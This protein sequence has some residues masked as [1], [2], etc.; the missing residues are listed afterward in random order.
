MGVSKI[1]MIFAFS[2]TCIS[3]SGM[4]EEA[5]E[6][7]D[8]ITVTATKTERNAFST[9][10]AVA[11]IDQEE[12]EQFIPSSFKDVLEGTPGLSIQGGARRIAEEP[13]IRG[14]SD[15]QLVLRLDGARQNFDQ[16]HRGRFFVDPAL[17]K[18]VEVIRGSASSLYGSGA[19]GGVLSLETKGAKDLLREGQDIGARASAGFQ[20]N[21][22]EF[23]VSGGVYGQA[24]KIDIL[25]NVVYREVF[26]DLI[27]GAG[28]PIVDSQDRIFNGHTKVGFEPTENQRF[29]I[30]ADFFDGNGLNPTASDDVSSAT[31][32]VDRNTKSYNIRGN[33]SY[34]NP[35]EPLVDLRAV[36][37]YGDVR[38]EE[39]RIFDGRADIS[40]FESYGI[41]IHNTSRFTAPD[42]NIVFALTYGF[43]YF[44]DKQDGTR[45]GEDRIE[46]PDAER[47]FAA[48]YAQLEVDLFDGAVSI[49]PGIRYDSL[50]LTSN[51]TFPSR[52][53]SDVTPRVSVG[54]TPIDQIYLWGSY[55][56]AFRAPT[57][58]EL[59]NDGVH[60]AVPNGF[61]PNTLVVNQFEPTP[62]LA[63][64]QAKSWEIGVR[65]RETDIGENGDN[66]VIGVNY[67]KT[68]VKNFVDT[69]VTYVDPMKP[70][71]FTPPFGPMTFFGTTQNVNAQAEIDGFEG[72]LRYESSLFEFSFTGFT[73][74]GVNPLTEV[75]LASI[76]PNSMT[77]SLIGKM[78]DIGLRYG[79]R[80]TITGAQEDVPEDS[81]TTDGYQTVDLFASWS[82]VDGVFENTVFSFAIDNV[83]NEDFSIHPTVIKQPGR[84]FRFNIAHQF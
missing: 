36:F 31:T 10:T 47:S 62:S 38:T 24:D 40:N 16:S 46:F 4:A 28:N 48:G 68:D 14:F 49:I 1:A 5:A 20:S 79:S 30:N 69:V 25:A 18:R 59:Y 55:S 34:N 37:H 2:T 50:D 65:F 57:L 39:N 67:F 82:P 26:H 42:E 43:E 32:V 6:N 22:D 66:F 54:V 80:L 58:T 63:A 15:Q 3:T 21:G 78:Q 77:L 9:P 45:D 51:G 84:S 71:Q 27:D 44:K 74:N 72:E 19:I 64:E 35:D 7:V 13:S 52:D 11:V 12:I 70:P 41:D 29:E 56:E 53:E 61:G 33:Y 17:I 76:A 73:A 60:F 8:V 75:G 81:V 83:F 23:F